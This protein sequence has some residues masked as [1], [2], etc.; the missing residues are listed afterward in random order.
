MRKICYVTGTRADFGLIRRTLHAIDD[1]QEFELSIVATGMHLEEKYGFTINEI[2]QFGFNIAAR[3]YN[4]R[5]DLSNGATMAHNLG[6]MICE[7]TDAFERISPDLILLLGDRGEM[8]AG[9]IAALHLNIPIAHIHGG[10]RS[11]TI[12]ESIRHAISK[13]AHY[14]FVSTIESRERLIR[15][16]EIPDRVFVVGA[17]GLDGIIDDSNVNRETLVSDF[18][19]NEK[20]KLALFVFHPVVQEAGFAGKEAQTILDCLLEHDLQIIALKPNSDA[21]S[22]SV[23]TVLEQ[24]SAHPDIRVITHLKRDVYLSLLAIADMLVG[25]SSSG[26]IEAASFGT[27]VLNVGT[28]QNLRERN[29]NVTDITADKNTLHNAINTILEKGRYPVDNLYG[30]GDAGPRMVSLLKKIPLSAA[31]LS[32]VNAY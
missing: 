31:I 17:P 8:L 2:E 3:I 19:L 22:T 7:M 27:P 4:K 32:K 21:G 12:D 6:K 20:S 11:G 10:E 18:K 28:R 9:A 24:Y 30:N 29:K 25:N 16:G 26:I 1:T 23:C 14:H 5:T 13:I 15:M